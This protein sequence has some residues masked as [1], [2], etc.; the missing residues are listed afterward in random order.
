[1][2]YK[3]KSL[4]HKPFLQFNLYIGIYTQWGLSNTF[5]NGVGPQM[6]A[7]VQ[8]KLSA[9]LQVTSC[10]RSDPLDHH[11]GWSQALSG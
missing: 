3:I 11:R 2:S 6:A 9:P 1:M 10:S 8:D 7:A 4:F 5:H